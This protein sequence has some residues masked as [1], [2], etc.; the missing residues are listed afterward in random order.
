LNGADLKD[1]MFWFDLRSAALSEIG[2]DGAENTE[3]AQWPPRFDER[4]EKLI[5]PSSISPRPLVEVPSRGISKGKVLSVQDGD[6]VMLATRTGRKKVRPIGIDAPEVGEAGADSAWEALRE[7]IPPGSW[8]HYSFDRRRTDNFG[9]ELVY[10]FG[11]AETLV[12]QSMLKRGAV[13]ARTDP[14]NRK[15]AFRNV[16]YARQLTAAEAWARQ[17]SK[18]LWEGCPP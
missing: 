17:R 15:K 14:P 16:H 2:L 18:G 4:V 13:I 10:L 12:N 3:D 1:A 9:R 11:S 7:L 5:D 8:V 6:T